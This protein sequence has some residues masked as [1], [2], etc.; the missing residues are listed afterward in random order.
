MNN[1]NG[2]QLP[3]EKE[4]QSDEIHADT[5]EG[6]ISRD[7]LLV[8]VRHYEEIFEMS[9]EEFLKRWEA[10]TVPDTFETNSWAMLLHA[11]SFE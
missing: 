9:S 3:N 5:P 6:I 8:R 7:E 11:L 4:R 1:R 2:T 10:D